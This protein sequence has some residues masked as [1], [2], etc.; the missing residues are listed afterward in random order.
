MKQIKYYK[1]T[2]NIYLRL[3]NLNDA[4]FIYNLRTNKKLSKYLNPTSLKFD[5]Q[6]LWMES[7]FK[8]Y[9]KKLEYYFKFQFKKKINSMT[10]VWLVLLSYHVA[11]QRADRHTRDWPLECTTH[12]HH[13]PPV[14]GG[15]FDGGAPRRHVR[16]PPPWAPRA[17]CASPGFA[18]SSRGSSCSILSQ[19]KM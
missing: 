16:C 18:R 1:L 12:P 8:R 14:G 2:K 6:I 13:R 5:D 17:A 7:Y 15:C 10:L 9:N 3:I 11:A 19:T 4:K